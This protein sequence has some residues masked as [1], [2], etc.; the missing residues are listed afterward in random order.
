MKCASNPYI[1]YNLFGTDIIIG[2][3]EEGK[4]CI[5]FFLQ[6]VYK[7]VAA[8]RIAALY[9]FGRVYFGKHRKSSF[10]FV[11]KSLNPQVK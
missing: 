10:K 11:F 8:T 2:M 5:T 7:I 3:R 1:G 6:I 9:I 4:T